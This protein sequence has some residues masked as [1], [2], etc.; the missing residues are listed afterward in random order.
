M[1]LG[2]FAT[3]LPESWET[4]HKMATKNWDRFVTMLR[5]GDQ[6]DIDVE[7]LSDLEVD[8]D[9]KNEILRLTSD[10]GE[11]NT[12]EALEQQSEL[13]SMGETIIPAALEDQ[14]TLLAEP[15]STPEEI[16]ENK[17][18]KDNA[19]FTR[20]LKDQAKQARLE[21]AMTNQDRDMINA[22]GN[23]NDPQEQPVM[24]PPERKSKSYT[25]LSL[26]DQWLQ[27]AKSPKRSKS[28]KRQE[29]CANNADTEMS[30]DNMSQSS[31]LSHVPPDVTQAQGTTSYLPPR[32]KSILKPPWKGD[33][34]Q[35]KRRH[36]R[37][38]TK[39][40]GTPTLPNQ[41]TSQCGQYNKHPADEEV[42][43]E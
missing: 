25:Q 8:T 11:D 33:S 40:A 34:N 10:A 23:K 26:T 22:E 35:R 18:T 19:V 1:T 5:E 32:P 21:T 37:K 31:G 42:V 43:P 17:T 20:E 39:N 9:S 28:S 27:S 2:D 7:R 6:T 29:S 4:H 16:Q 15:F 3:P 41:T 36:P 12:D 13:Q 14:E 30:A 24:Q 38:T